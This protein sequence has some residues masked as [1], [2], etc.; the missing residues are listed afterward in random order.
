[1]LQVKQAKLQ[2][3]QQA[4]TQQILKLLHVA[5][6]DSLANCASIATSTGLS[7]SLVQRIQQAQAATAAMQAALAA[8]QGQQGS[9]SAPIGIEAGSAAHE[10]LSCALHQFESLCKPG[11][12]DCGVHHTAR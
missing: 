1:V 6:P 3:L 4:S 7:N 5:D 8:V 2:L 10:Q 11:E 12:S 9:S